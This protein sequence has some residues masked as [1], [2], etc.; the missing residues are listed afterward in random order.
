[1]I[2]F[3][4]I[5][6]IG[7][8]VPELEPQV[9]LM[10]DLFGF[11]RSSRRED[12]E[13]GYRAVML[14]MPGTDRIGWEVLEPLGQGSSL[15]EFIDGPRGPGVHHV[16]V[17]VPDVNA[18]A[19]E[20]RSKGLHPSLEDAPGQ[21]AIHPDHG[22][23]GFLF[24][25]FE[26]GR[27][28]S[29]EQEQPSHGNNGSAGITRLDHLCHAYPDREELRDWYQSIFGMREIWR[30]PD[31][32]HPDIADLVLEI[33]EHETFWEIIQPVGDESFIQRF[34]DRR[35][36]SIHHATFK[37]ADWEQAQQACEDRGAP[38]FDE[39]SGE[40]DGARWHDAFIHPRNTGGILVQLFWEEQ[41]GV[42]IRSDKIRPPGWS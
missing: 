11:K 25:F 32:E 7:M 14:E 15:Q 10:E 23:H 24:R 36:P 29:G 20:L 5:D 21:L 33:P 40:T 8:V 37:V 31:G 6:H 39:N 42:W 13:E 17:E 2:K 16:S 35:G 27:R 4:R 19:E 22:G 30:T 3:N 12:K 18:A 9:K 1:M 38:L 34:L 28:P 26:P 41:P